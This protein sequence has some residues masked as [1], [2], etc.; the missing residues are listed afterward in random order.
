[1]WSSLR[2]F[3]STFSDEGV[4]D[5]TV[6]LNSFCCI[7]LSRSVLSFFVST[8]SQMICIASA[9]FSETLRSSLVVVLSFSTSV[10]IPVYVSCREV[11]ICCTVVLAISCLHSWLSSHSSFF[12][13]CSCCAID[14]LQFSNLVQ[15]CS[16]L[17]KGHHC[18]PLLRSFLC[19]CLLRFA[20][21]C[22]SFWVREHV[23]R[24]ALVCYL[25]HHR[26]YEFGY[27]EG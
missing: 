9:C 5:G 11:T 26:A 22:Y 20:R 2:V 8:L 21:C 3:V 10:K 24:L 19:L 15:L 4:G 12:K 18:S 13:Q 1:M 7:V 17:S 23:S 6:Y 25:L 16:I 14:F 27:F